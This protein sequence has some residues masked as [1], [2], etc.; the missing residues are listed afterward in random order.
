[1]KSGTTLKRKKEKIKNDLNFNDA[2]RKIRGQKCFFKL[3]V[4]DNYIHLFLPANE[5]NSSFVQLNAINSKNFL[6]S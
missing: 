5:K 6:S 2:N 1:M 3:I 4:N